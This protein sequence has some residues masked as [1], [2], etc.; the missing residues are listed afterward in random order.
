MKI[1]FISIV[2]DPW[3]GSEELW[4]KTAELALE[5]GHSV[6]IS[7]FNRPDISPKFLLLKS[8]GARLLLR[9]GYIKSGTGLYKRV[10]QKALNFLL[11]KIINPYTDLFKLNPDIIIYTGACYSLADDPE[12]VH[13]LF[14]YDTP[15][16]I[17][18]QVNI[19]YSKPINEN[20]ASIIRKAY[21]RADR[22]LFVSERNI[23][24]AQRHL[25]SRIENQEII[26][27]TVN[28][29][30]TSIIDFPS[31]NSTVKFAIV[32]NLLVNH[33]G[34]DILL[35]ILRSAK[36]QARS[37]KLDIYGSGND[38]KYITSLITFYDLGDRVKLCGRTNDI[39]KV[40]E[41]NHALLMPSLNE[42]IPLALVEAMI[43]GRPVVV[44]DVG[45]N[46]EWISDSENGYIA[47]GAN[48][49]SFDRAME[50]AWNDMKNWPTVG[51][52]AHERA[53]SMFDPHAGE[54]FLNLILKHG[55]RP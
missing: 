42:G 24:T 12:L 30:D 46:S 28:L 43:C 8:K 49:M 34:H 19:E 32:A 10:A 20:E 54:T 7:A 16:L 1:A 2:R 14:R 35:D 52:K 15:F 29:S 5:S 50:R 4:A 31:D 48:I 44:T 39:R 23:R 17:N 13:L 45:G 53:I 18:N 47:E 9:R 21:E 36:W 37:W 3:G 33:K 38:E 55:R 26:R 27:N 40:W 22:V 51:K 6:F 11:N 41:E 25:L